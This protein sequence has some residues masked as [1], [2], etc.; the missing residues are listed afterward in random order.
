MAAMRVFEEVSP[1]FESIDEMVLAIAEHVPNLAPPE[2][3]IDQAL[4]PY[5]YTDPPKYYKYNRSRYHSHSRRSFSN[6][7]T[8]WSLVR[9]TLKQYNLIE[10]A[11]TVKNKP[12]SSKNEKSTYSMCSLHP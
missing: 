7:E 6:P 5:H 11:T 10:G 2:W 12:Q 3:K 8:L 4:I 1:F 9:K